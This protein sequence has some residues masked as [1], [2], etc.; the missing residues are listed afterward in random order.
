MAIEARIR[1]LGVRHQTLERAIHD[2]LVRPAADD[3][4]LRDLKLQKLKVK[5]ELES[6]RAHSSN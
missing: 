4:K 5:E 3:L 1:E 2:E 6:L